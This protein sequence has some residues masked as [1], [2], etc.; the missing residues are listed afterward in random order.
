VIA[1][2]ASL[3]A[4]LLTLLG[5]APALA[6]PAD[7]VDRVILRNGE[8][9]S[10]RFSEVV[11]NVR[12]TI[13]VANGE[14]RRIAWQEIDR[15]EAGSD[16]PADVAPDSKSTAAT[17]PTVRTP[18]ADTPPSSPSPTPMRWYGWQ[19]LLVD[20]SAA[21]LM[22]G[23]LA[24]NEAPVDFEARSPWFLQS[25]YLLRAFVALENDPDPAPPAPTVTFDV[26]LALFSVGAPI[27]HAFNGR[28][29]PTF[30]SA[31]MRLVGPATGVVVGGIVG[32][33]LYLPIAFI[34]PK[35]KDGEF[36]PKSKVAD[37][38]GIGCVYGGAALGLVGPIIIDAIWLARAPLVRETRT[39]R[40]TPLFVPR[41][42]VVGGGIMG[43][44]A[45]D[46]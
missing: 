12:V 32:G 38:V 26:G 6:Q 37:S 33:L 9:V 3:A 35:T 10:G 13:V 43:T 23:G 2:L 44:L 19:T 24:Q 31:G 8:V 11:P 20:V 17:P 40:A 4:L 16:T 5:S 34:D 45:F 15:I 14:V 27:V 39:T 30:V 42:G 18:P 29:V 1:R 41:V 7:P 21:G 25:S 46:L 22:L 36:F 28:L